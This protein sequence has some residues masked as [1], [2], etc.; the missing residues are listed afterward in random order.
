MQAPQGN[1]IKE[2][3]ESEPHRDFGPGLIDLKV[4]SWDKIPTNKRAPSTP[5]MMQQ[6]PPPS[7][8]I[9][10][11]ADR[12]TRQQSAGKPDQLDLA[13]QIEWTYDWPA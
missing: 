3:L 4:I 5:N 13:P 11:G 7:T 6:S 12:D 2:T 9:T 1:T 8:L 10:V